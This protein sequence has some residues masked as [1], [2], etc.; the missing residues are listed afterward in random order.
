ML[1]IPKRQA[2]IQ[3]NEEADRLAKEAS[4]E[5]ESMTEED[6]TVSQAEFRQAAK[7]HSLTA[8]QKQWDVSEKGRFLYGLKPKVSKKTVFDFPDKKSYNLIT[9]L[10][11]GYA[12][13][14]DYL[15]KIGV[16]QQ[17]TVAVEK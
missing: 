13:L 7:A 1:I 15:F 6:R 12:R 8:W 3:G 17:E 4:K 10:I 5:A 2:E 16:S 14:N 9:Q 11:I